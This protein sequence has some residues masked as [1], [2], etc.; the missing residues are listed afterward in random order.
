MWNYVG[1]VHKQ[2]LQRAQNRVDYACGGKST[3][4]QQLHVTRDLLELRTGTGGRSVI[5]VPMQGRE[6]RGLHYTLGLSGLLLRLQVLCCSH[7]HLRTVKRS[8][9][10]TAQASSAAGPGQYERF[11][12][13]SA[14]AR[15]NAQRSGSADKGIASSGGWPR[16]ITTQEPANPRYSNAGGS[17]LA[18]RRMD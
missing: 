7:P 14:P 13:T 8:A 3:V 16:S 12:A 5:P 11:T 15:A 9:S 4:Y 1:I 17:E 18:C 10:A 2:R 6:S